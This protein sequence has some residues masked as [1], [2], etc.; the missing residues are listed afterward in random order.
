MRWSSEVVRG[1]G[2]SA[3]SF[4]LESNCNLGRIRQE[5]PGNAVEVRVRATTERSS[6][7]A[8]RSCPT[9][10]GGLFPQRS[11]SAAESYTC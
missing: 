5:A 3:A 10:C 11:L 1:R 2:D 8:I 9:G 6:G 7:T 4:A